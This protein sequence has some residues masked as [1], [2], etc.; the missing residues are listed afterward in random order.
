[1]KYFHLAFQNVKKSYKD[2][3][4]YFLTLTFSIC[5]FYTF[6]SFQAQ[7][8]IMKMNES[9]NS[10]MSTVSIFMSMLSVFVAIVLA[11][12]VL[13]ANNFLVRRRKKEFGLYMILGMPQAQISRILV[14]ETV[15]IGAISLVTGLAMGVLCSQGLGLVTARM[16][17][18]EVDYH[19]VFSMS[20]CLM[21]VI[22]FTVIFVV[23]MLLNT[24]VIARVKLIELLRAEKQVEKQRLVRPILSVLLFIVS[25]AM[26]GGAYKLAT[27]SLTVFASMLVPILIL[28]SV[29]TLVFF[30]SL[31]G[32]L[33][34]FI[35][36]SK[37][38]YLKNLNM[39]VLR[40]I[41]A[42]INTNFVSMS[43][44]C[45]ML[46]LSIGALA[47]GWNMNKSMYKSMEVLTPYTYSYE[48]SEN[49]DQDDMKNLLMLEDKEYRQINIYE[50]NHK[51]KEL[52]PYL[53]DDAKDFFYK[54]GPLQYVRYS[55]YAQVMSD[56]HKKPVT[57]QPG[58]CFA[59]SGNDKINTELRDIENAHITAF[60]QKLTMKSVDH[61]VFNM[62]DA[63]ASNNI[64]TIVVEDSLIPDT[65]KPVLTYWNVNMPESEIKNYQ[66]S[67]KERLDTYTAQHDIKYIYSGVSRLEIE[68]SSVGLGLLFTYIGL[69]LG[70]VFLMA[71]AAILAIQQLSEA[72]DNKKRYEILAKIGTSPSM[73]NKAIRHQIGI[74]F[75][76]PLLLAIVHSVV[77]VKVV[78]GSFETIFGLGDMTTANLFTGAVIILIY[79]SYYLVTYYG[80]RNILNHK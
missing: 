67:A 10:M 45:L 35:K 72:E 56:L 23:I 77:G 43:I 63:Y 33:L 24:R 36:K 44:V 39:F 49:I 5:L 71:S 68:E 25:L 26:I 48:Q 47:T 75:V 8:E 50:D 53:S 18:V 79:G 7:Q 76:L 61:E 80:Y 78:A 4:V 42:K 52:Y 69:Y 59:T 58:E 38:L 15:M 41:H 34:Q 40:Q 3:F 21:T 62:A 66:K 70:I 29:G 46:L 14:Y 37:V 2:Y 6:N 60:H 28:G 12:L 20:A 30:F 73:M 55:D 13:Y 19:I 11:F 22:S 57:I 64:I 17:M 27:S 31:S 16:F 1:M 32:F 65:A 9:Q 74:Y 54:E 51:V